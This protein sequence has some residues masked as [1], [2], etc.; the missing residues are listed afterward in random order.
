MKLLRIII[1]IIAIFSLVGCK[2]NISNSFK[3]PKDIKMKD[4]IGTIKVTYDNDGTFT[5]QKDG[6]FKTLDN[7]QSNFRISFKFADKRVS[8]IKK[9]KQNY[10]QAT[11]YDVIDN[12]EHNG[13]KGFVVINKNNLTAQVYLYIK[14]NKSITLIVKI[15]PI[16]T[17]DAIES[18]KDKNKPQDVLYKKKK[19]QDILNTIKYTK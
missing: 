14:K 8:D 15:T 13:Y 17:K 6:N 2:K 19:V 10:K 12:I 9:L 1:V 7:R 18:L 5:E 11:I 4:D 16:S 3:N